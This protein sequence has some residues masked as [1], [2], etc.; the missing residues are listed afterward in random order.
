MEAIGEGE[1]P[2]TSGPTKFWGSSFLVVFSFSVSLLTL[3][4]PFHSITLEVSRASQALTDDATA[5]QARDGTH[6]VMPSSPALRAPFASFRPSMLSALDFL[7]NNGSF[8]P[9]I[10][11]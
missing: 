1:N 3:P 9:P 5:H 4:H 2:V 8:V 11:C 7:G 10:A 6:K